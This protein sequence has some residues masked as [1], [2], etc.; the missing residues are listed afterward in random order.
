MIPEMLK[1]WNGE[2]E[3]TAAVLE[4]PAKL[5]DFSTS[6]NWPKLEREC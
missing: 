2:L 1:A 4:M 5:Q 6:K 3:P